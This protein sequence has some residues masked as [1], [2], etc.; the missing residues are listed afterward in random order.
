MITGDFSLVRL[1]DIMSAAPP[2][3]T[4]VEVEKL[5]WTYADLNDEAQQASLAN[6]RL[7]NLEA[8]K[9]LKQAAAV[10]LLIEGRQGAAHRVNAHQALSSML[11]RLGDMAAAAHAACAALRAAREAGSRTWLITGLSKCGEV[12]RHAPDEM[13][14]E[15]RA[16]S[17]SG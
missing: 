10:A 12:A 4:P 3:P 2:P 5:E 15:E 11:L 14:K 1:S 8:V 17:R 13:A 6:T 7:G 9:K 16:E